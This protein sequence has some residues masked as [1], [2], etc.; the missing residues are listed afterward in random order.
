MHQ[1]AESSETAVAEAQEV[2]ELPSLQM[3]KRCLDLALG[4]VQGLQW[5]CQVD[6]PL[7]DLKDLFQTWCSMIP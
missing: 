6:D 3:F 4:D 5:Q 7:G 2:M 1:G